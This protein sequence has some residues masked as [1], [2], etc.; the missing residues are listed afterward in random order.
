MYVVDVN[1]HYSFAHPRASLWEIDF[2]LTL[3]RWDGN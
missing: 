3:T 2:D 1:D